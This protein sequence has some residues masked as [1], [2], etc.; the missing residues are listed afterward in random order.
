MYFVIGFSGYSASSATLQLNILWP[1]RIK[2]RNGQAFPLQIVLG[3]TLSAEATGEHED[4][5][6]LA[7]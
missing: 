5:V 7:V 4:R 2:C 6:D 3:K 1:N